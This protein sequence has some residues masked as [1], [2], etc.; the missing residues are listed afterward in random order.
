MNS[1]TLGKKLETIQENK[2]FLNGMIGFLFALG[3]IS[4]YVT[5]FQA[6]SVKAG[7]IATALFFGFFLY[8]EIEEE[9]TY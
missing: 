8:L 2:T 4:F 1:Q 7:I 5:I 9:D 6:R 3:S